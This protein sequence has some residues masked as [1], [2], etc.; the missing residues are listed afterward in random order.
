MVINFFMNIDPKLCFII[1]IICFVVGFLIWFYLKKCKRLKYDTLTMVTGGVKTG[2]ST[3]TLHL[4]YKQYKKQLKKYNFQM[5]VAKFLHCEFDKEKPLFYS[6]IPLAFDY[7]P[8]DMD[9]MLRHKRF[10]YGSVIYCDESSLLADSMDCKDKFTNEMLLLFNKLIGHETGGIN[11][12]SIGEGYLFY[13]T[14]SIG[15]NHFSV[16]RCLTRYY[17]IY[18]T[19]K[20]VPFVIL[21]RVRE[22]AYQDGMDNVTNQFSEDV[23]DTMRWVIVPKS[24]WK[25][26]DKCC[27]SYLT[28]NL[29]VASNVVDGK[30][31]D[32]LKAK[33]V[34]SF[35]KFEQ[36]QVKAMKEEIKEITS[37]KGDQKHE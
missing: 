26:F 33:Y 2:K 4:A 27:Y 13:D 20:F 19:I 6:N 34:L 12:K 29:E 24:I 22:M 28:D 31:L 30:L 8:L 37:K 15:D 17:W 21:M 3:L 7:V 11:S 36:L 14:Q 1:L 16:K 9:L 18:Q 23:V 32:D 10:A 35:H 5:K 25:K